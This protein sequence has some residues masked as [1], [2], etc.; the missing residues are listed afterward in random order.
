MFDSR[1]QDTQPFKLIKE[2]RE[3]ALEIITSLVVDLYAIAC[4]LRPFLPET[5]AKIIKLIHE[6]KSPLEPLFLRKD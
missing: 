1:I 3:Q 5:S 2:D 6:N 4:M